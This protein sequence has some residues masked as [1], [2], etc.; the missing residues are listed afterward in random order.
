[1]E[2]KKFGYWTILA[3]AFGSIIGTGLFTGAALG[4]NFSGNMVII[5]WIIMSV[6]GVYIAA[7]FGELVAMFPKSGGVYEYGKQAYGRFIS[8][9][10]GW[11]AWLVGTISIALLIVTAINFIIPDGSNLFA[12]IAISISIVVLLNLIAFI[13]VEMSSF[14]LLAFAAIMVAV[15]ATIIIR[16]IT[17]VNAQN[18][19]PF[20]SHDFSAL[21]VTIFFIM[22]SYFGWEA[23]TYLAEETE[24]PRKVIPKALM[25]G[26]LMVAVFG[27]MMMVVMLG[28]IPYS[29]LAAL[30]H[31]NSATCDPI[32]PILKIIFGSFGIILSVG[33]VLIM[34]GSAAGGI[35]SLPRL[36]LALARDKLMLGQLKHLHSVFNTPYK[37]IVFQTIML[38]LVLLFGFAH[39][40][41]L[42][43]VLVPL[44]LAMYILSLLAVSILRHTQPEAERS[45]KVPFGN[46]GPII[47]SLIFLAVIVFWIMTVKGSSSLLFLGISLALFGIPIYFLIEMYYDPKMITSVNDIFSHLTLATE[48]FTFPRKIRK[49]ILGF[50][51]DIKGKAVLEFGCSVGTLTIPLAKAVGS[52][53]KIY[54]THFSEHDLKIVRR[55]L[56]NKKWET[57][58]R[59]YGQVRL[60]HDFEH[61]VRL[62]PDVKYA[63][64]AVSAGMLSYMQ[65]PKKIL[66]E[67]ASVLP[68]GG[69]V[70]FVEYADFFHIIPNKEWLSDD[71]K[72]A[73]VFREAGLS[74]KVERRKGLFWN[75]IFIYGFKLGKGVA[76]I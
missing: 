17:F 22:E 43:G 12:K 42:L 45:F 68:S 16:G 37:A 32:S 44:A 60:I 24:N 29:E 11:V 38:I 65:Q 35:I 46:I 14:V 73:K 59:V 9:M 31:P 25:V 52:T 5:A 74:V 20:F 39:Y 7:C 55:R 57:E 2:Q 71:M 76:Y 49:E 70:C 67:I 15:I 61:L 66:S 4:A 62:H 75:H 40:Q 13:G 47:I 8:F 50:L 1:M 36:L 19:S 28:I 33:I 26:T 18:F 64:A 56:I 21:F 53:G 3:L 30:C 10:I 23:A 41:T 34:I 58:K 69:K 48:H 27:V 54:A 63:D 51:G 72:I 6:I